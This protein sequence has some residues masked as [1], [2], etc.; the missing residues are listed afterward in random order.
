VEELTLAI[1]HMLQHGDVPVLWDVR[2][3]E[4]AGHLEKFES[5]LRNLLARWSPEAP[6]T[7]GRAFVVTGSARGELETLLDKL[8]LPWAWG[9]FESA[10]DALDWLGTGL[11]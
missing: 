4:L 10:D 9:V 2:Q 5:T 6:C 1:Q 7:A 3:V 8:G 11:P